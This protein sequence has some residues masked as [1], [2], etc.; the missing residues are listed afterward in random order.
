LRR[1]HSPYRDEPLIEPCPVATWPAGQ[2]ID[3]HVVVGARSVNDGIAAHVDRDVLRAMSTPEEQQV[4]LLERVTRKRCLTH[5]RLFVRCTRKN[6]AMKFEYIPD[7]ARAIECS[8]RSTA[9][10]I[11]GPEELARAPHDIATL[12]D[13]TGGHDAQGWGVRRRGRG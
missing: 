11:R 1:Q 10:T 9:E 13:R 6:Y 5:G 4:A 8:G 12:D 7:K 3:P 2:A